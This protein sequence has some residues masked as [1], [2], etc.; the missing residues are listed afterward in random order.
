MMGGKVIVIAGVSGC[1]KSTV[2]QKMAS[3]WTT[4]DEPASFYDGD[5]FHPEAN[6][7]K[8]SSGTPL[9]DDDRDPWL[10]TLSFKISTWIAEGKH[11]VLACSALKHKYRTILL[12]VSISTLLP[13]KLSS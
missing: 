4:E 10:R 8:M 13:N 12:K 3:L 2:G 6:I 9:N 5:D 7:Q 11:I 1:G